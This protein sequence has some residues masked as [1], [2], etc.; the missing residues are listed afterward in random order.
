M[1]L[2]LSIPLD[3]P[4]ENR[5]SPETLAAWE[6]LPRL[7]Q[8]EHGTPAEEAGRLMIAQPGLIVR[9]TDRRCWH[10][11]PVSGPDF[12]AIEPTESDPNWMVWLADDERPNETLVLHPDLAEACRLCLRRR[13]GK[14]V[15][16]RVDGVVNRLASVLG[17][18]ASEQG[19]RQ[20]ASVVTAACF[21]VLLF[22]AGYA[23]AG[24][25]RHDAAAWQSN[26]RAE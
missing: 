26:G 9:R 8:P 7:G 6:R 15:A 23:V 10:I 1:S 2:T 17:D 21:A 3:L 24:G 20:I 22:A 18:A 4:R 25:P 5:V 12:G 16:A 14:L 11:Q 19:Q 13:L